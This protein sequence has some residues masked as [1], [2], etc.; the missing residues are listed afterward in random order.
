[1]MSVVTLISVIILNL[2]VDVNWVT[3]VGFLR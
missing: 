3:V 1:M 2:C